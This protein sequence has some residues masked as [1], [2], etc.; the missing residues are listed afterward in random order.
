MGDGLGGGGGSGLGAIFGLASAFAESQAQQEQSVYTQAQSLQNRD[1]ANFAAADAVDRGNQQVGRIR[2][3]GTDLV[4]AQ[5][6]AYANSGVDP[7]VGTAADV[8]ADTA[9]ITEQDARTATN[10]AAREAWGFRQQAAKFEQ[11]KRL[12]ESRN[13][14]KQAGTWLTALGRLA[15]G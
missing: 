6:G 9:T 2:K 5:R 12:E 1:Q 14:A 7:T 4:A 8:Q 15:G 13:N 3:Q 11:E 10:N